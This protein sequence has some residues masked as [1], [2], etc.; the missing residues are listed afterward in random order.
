VIR[1]EQ[2]RLRV[3]RYRARQHGLRLEAAAAKWD[4]PDTVEHTGQDDVLS[5]LQ[6]LTIDE[7]P[8]PKALTNRSLDTSTHDV[9]CR[10]IESDFGYQTERT[11]SN[12]SED[13]PSWN[14]HSDAH[15]AS[16]N[17]T[18]PPSRIGSHPVEH[19]HDK[20]C[21]GLDRFSQAIQGQGSET[22]IRT[23]DRAIL[24]YD[25][26]FKIFF[27]PRCSCTLNY[28]I[29]ILLPISSPTK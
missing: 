28:R 24:I 10:T 29:K 11:H 16:P 12:L 2:T 4:N 15:Q 13:D 5:G 18:R 19:S 21:A 26:M 9:E 23:I 1:R 14:C 3:Q 27:N 25:Q 7:A 6:D 17:A 22:R 20:I 8:H